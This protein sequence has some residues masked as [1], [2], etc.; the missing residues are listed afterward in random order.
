MEWKLTVK[1]FQQ[2]L[3]QDRLLGLKCTSCAGVV[4]PPIAICPYC[5]GA[6]FDVLELSGSGSIKTFTVIWTAPEGFQ[7]P[8]IVGIVE[9]DDGPWLMGNIIGI[10]PEAADMRLI[11][12]RVKLCHGIV[13]GDKHSAG[14]MV[15]VAFK[16]DA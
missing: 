6:G 8:Y 3:R 5:G 1:D 12:T 14:E 10:E 4:C 13:P 2:A 15:A 9:T 11:G 7:P 16:I